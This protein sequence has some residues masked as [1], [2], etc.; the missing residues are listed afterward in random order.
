M[1][2]AA[3]AFL[4]VLV[5]GA[6]GLAVWKISQSRR[7]ERLAED[8][9]QG[10]EKAL[11]TAEQ[12]RI[13]ALTSRTHAISG[14][15]GEFNSRRG[16]LFSADLTRVFVRSD[17]RA[18]RFDDAESEDV[19]QR[20]QE[21]ICCFRVTLSDQGF[22]KTTARLVLS[23]DPSLASELTSRGQGQIYTIVARISAV[24]SYEDVK[25]GE[26]DGWPD[27]RR[28]TVSG[29]ELAQEHLKSGPTRL[30]DEI[31]E[32]SAVVKSK[33]DGANI[34]LD[35]EFV[36]STPSTVKLADGDHT[37]RLQKPGFKDWSR[38]VKIGPDGDITIDAVL[39]KL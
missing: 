35:T 2:L 5:L 29:T 37:I 26:S 18:I 3:R 15:N 12:Q 25:T 8:R 31:L 17:G 33:P 10:Q 13:G 16:F 38:T 9:E 1:Q 34:F 22:A 11:K 6:I 7:N 14:W 32:T 28:F 27:E 23:C 39:E 19:V 21:Y 30:L 20:G 24:P 36:G 4:L